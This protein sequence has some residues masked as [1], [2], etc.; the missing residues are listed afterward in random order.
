ML[1][2]PCWQCQTGNS[3]DQTHCAGCG[4][5]LAQSTT[6]TSLA[7]KASTSL[8]TRLR[9]SPILRSP[10]AKSVALGLAA[11]AVDLGSNLL[12]KRQKPAAAPTTSLATKPAAAQ[13]VFL[14]Q[15]EWQEFDE[16][17]TLR[18]HVV[19]RLIIRDE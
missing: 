11:L 5:D 17:G 18:R 12:S 4:A 14:R 8:T 6:T 10:V 1:E 9:Q 2:R 16:Q 13:R 3:L 15:R 7:T 19:E